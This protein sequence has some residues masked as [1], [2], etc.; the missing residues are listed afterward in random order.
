[1][2]MERKDTILYFEYPEIQTFVQIKV[3]LH[4]A[5]GTCPAS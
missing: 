5:I 2:E 3:H 1:M 4:F